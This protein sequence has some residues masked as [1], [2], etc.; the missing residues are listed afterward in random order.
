MV[1]MNYPPQQAYPATTMHSGIYQVG[2]DVQPG[3]YETTGPED[4][5]HPLGCYWAQLE[6]NSG[7]SGEIINNG[8]LD[9]PG[10]IRINEGEFVELRGDRTWTKAG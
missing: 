6:N 3:Q 1:T 4:K 2:A 10:S 9:G 8:V 5:T 7:Q